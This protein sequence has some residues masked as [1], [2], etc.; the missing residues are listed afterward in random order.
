MSELLIFPKTIIILKIQS[1]YNC[2]TDK[3]PLKVVFGNN[4]YT[5]IS[6]S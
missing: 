3:M 2:N 1:F 5:H 6:E 4:T